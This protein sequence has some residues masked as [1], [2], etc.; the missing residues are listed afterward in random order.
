VRK[1]IQ[2]VAGDPTSLPFLKGF[3]DNAIRNVHSRIDGFISNATLDA[4][5]KEN[6]VL[7]VGNCDPKAE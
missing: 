2:T 5:N 7:G 6:E 1:Q 4:T 3:P